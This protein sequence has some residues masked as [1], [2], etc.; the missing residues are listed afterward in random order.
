L[1]IIDVAR[2]IASRL[3]FDPGWETRPVWSP[4]GRR[5]AFV[6]APHGRQP[7]G[8]KVIYVMSANGADARRLSRWSLSLET[9][10][11]LFDP[12]FRAFRAD[13]LVR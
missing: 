2:G 1:W 5:I 11:F 7:N 12:P 13:G 6:H 4:D 3:T 10:K 9:L 8:P